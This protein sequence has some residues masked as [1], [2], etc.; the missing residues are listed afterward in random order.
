MTG[1]IQ[2]GRSRY[3]APLSSRNSNSISPNLHV[4]WQNPLCGPRY[5]L[6]IE[7]ASLSQFTRCMAKAIF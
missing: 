5:L 4:V 6:E 1:V 7:T 3:A 2:T